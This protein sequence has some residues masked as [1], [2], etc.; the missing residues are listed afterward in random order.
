MDRLLKLYN[1]KNPMFSFIG[2]DF[3]TEEFSISNLI[4]VPIDSNWDLICGPLNDDI[5]IDFISLGSRDR[6]Y[7]EPDGAIVSGA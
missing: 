2:C 1:T 7:I 3:S 4:Y 5:W 6:I